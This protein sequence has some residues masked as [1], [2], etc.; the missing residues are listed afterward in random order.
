MGGMARIDSKTYRF[1][2]VNPQNTPVMEQLGVEVAPLRTIYDFA[3]GGVGMRL[4][5][6]TPMLPED[7][8]LVSRPVTY[9]TW[10]VSSADGKPHDVSVYF[11][12][13]AEWAANSPDQ[14]VAWTRCRAGNLTVMRVGTV[15]Q[16]VLEKKGDN[17]RIDWGHLYVA[18]P[19]EADPETVMRGHGVR[20][21]FARKGV[22][23]DTD[24]LRMP[25]AANDEYPVLACAL[26]LGRVDASATAM[27]WLMVA[28]DDEY[29]LE[30]MQRR[31]RPYW[32]RN[33]RDAPALLLD[34]A[35]DYPALVKRCRAFDDEVMA[36][37]RKT[38]G[39]PFAKLAALAFRQCLAAHK[40]AADYDGSPIHMSKENFSNGCIATVDV[41][42]PASPFFLL[43][44]PELLKAQLTPLLHYASSTR[45]KFPFAPHDLGT[46]PLANGQAYGGG[47]KSEENQMPVEES[48][49][50]L[51]MLAALAKIDGNA[52]YAEKYWPV[53]EQWAGYLREK[54]MDPENQL[55]TDDFAGHIA[56][57]TNLSLKAIVALGCYSQLC[58]MLGKTGEATEYGNLARDMARRWMKDA[59][60]GDHYRL[61]F[62]KP[63]TW[64]QKYNLVW[65]RILGLGLFPDKVAHKE[66]AYYV[67]QLNRYGLPLDNRSKYTKL[68]W[69][70]WSASLAPDRKAFDSLIR[71]L[72]DF[73]NETPDRVP[74]TDW[75]WTHDARLRGFRAR[76]V[77]GGVY[78]PLL[79]DPTLWGK[80]SGRSSVHRVE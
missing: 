53:V 67:Q 50:M 54:G 46:Y 47:E 2:G 13:S 35:R 52:A 41:I 49:N 63:G 40:L 65:D 51:I 14:K 69:A 16:P 74:L 33:G 22:L 30:Y 36:D 32:R 9:I 29:S 7:L 1:M 21:T 20:D 6:M 57:N 3:A 5:F 45:W 25:R 31:L 78:I 76:P 55:C 70:V 64:S 59:D 48:G 39:E 23:P 15:E 71:P 43:F 38:G 61:T 62:D 58:R 79:F 44:S 19:R 42:Y 68:D 8:D 18:V 28:Y 11:D 27:R 37:L 56:H 75:Y 60:D 77:V 66:V 73:A 10:N 80:W 17:L 72:Y 26:D 4:T 34:A 24:D 12:C